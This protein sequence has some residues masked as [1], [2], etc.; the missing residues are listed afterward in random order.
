MNP[1]VSIGLPVYN[2]E[3][4]L[5]EALDSI[6][7]QSFGDFE[8]IVGD[9]ASTDGSRD[10][11]EEYA[12][13]DSRINYMRLPENV[14]AA[15]NFN[16]VFHGATGEF[17]KWMAHDDRIEPAFLTRCIGAFDTRAPQP[18]VVYTKTDLI[19]ENGRVIGLNEPKME[20]SSPQTFVRAFEVIQGMGA[21]ADAVFGL[22]RR[23]ML[24]QTRLIG[25]FFAADR[26]LLFEAALLGEIVRL[27]GKPLL[28]RRVHPGMSTKAQVSHEER[29]KWYD[30]KAQATVSP[31]TKIVLEY[32][33]S[34]GRM[35][36][37]SPLDRAL[38]FPATLAGVAVRKT[39][40]PLGRYRRRLWRRQSAKSRLS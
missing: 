24:E 15:A 8:L 36:N 12:L 32:L 11:C 20:T 6:L 3:R 38:C 7:A 13:R 14:G 34:A 18:V 27:E 35:E 17:F 22:F 39:R 10:I 4:Y 2:G 25:S 31:E 23:S 9:N 19:D 5:A 1:R 40:V 26:V 21:V 28:Q 33:R 29:L 37:L 16:R 30:P